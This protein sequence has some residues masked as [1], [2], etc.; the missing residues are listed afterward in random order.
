MAT[1]LFQ[2]LLQKES[3]L[4]TFSNAPFAVVF[5]TKRQAFSDYLYQPTTCEKG[6]FPH[7]WALFFRH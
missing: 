4:K 6:G 3:G 1:F 5:F 7:E 2:R